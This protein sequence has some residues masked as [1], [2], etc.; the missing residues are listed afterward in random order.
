ML[1]SLAF[2]NVSNITGVIERVVQEM[3]FLTSLRFNGASCGERMAMDM[4][5]TLSG[6]RS[7]CYLPRDGLQESTADAMRISHLTQLTGLT[8]LLYNKQIPFCNQTTLIELDI[9]VSVQ[10]DLSDAISRLTLLET[11]KVV[12]RQQCCLE[13][14][15]VLR[16]LR[17]LKSTTLEMPNDIGGDFFPA[18]ASL[19]ALTFLQFNCRNH[20]DSVPFLSEIALVKNLKTLSV[21][22]VVTAHP[23]RFLQRGSLPRLRSLRIQPF[24]DLKVTRKELHRRFPCLASITP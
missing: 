2:D 17:H 10:L 18:L 22:H 23:L 8:T 16:N 15:S 14:P 11:L 9:L 4:L 3:I 5:A 19:P 6:L 20:E 21:E 1:R 13:T 12:N 24:P 7:L